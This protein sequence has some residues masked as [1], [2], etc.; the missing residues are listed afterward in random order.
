MSK[1][2]KQPSIAAAHADLMSEVKSVDYRVYDLESTVEFLMDEIENLKRAAPQR[3]SQMSSP[4]FVAV[5]V[6]GTT[7]RMTTNCAGD[8]AVFDRTAKMKLDLGR[9]IR[10]AQAAY[11][12]RK[13]QPP[14]A[15]V[16]GLFRSTAERQCWQDSENLYRQRRTQPRES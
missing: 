1:G 5:F 3:E 12:S 6:D 4:T 15:L 11:E 10:L 13:K 7:T 8:G 14:P 16:E 9:G 2:S